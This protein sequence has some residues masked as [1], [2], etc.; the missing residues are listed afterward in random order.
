MEKVKSATI[1]F[2]DKLFKEAQVSCLELN[3]KCQ[4]CNEAVQVIVWKKDYE[5][6]GNGGM[7]VGDW[8]DARPE[9][10]CGECL[11]KDGGKISPTRCEVFSRVVGY[12]RPIQAFNK[13]KKEEFHMRKN[14]SMGGDV[15]NLDPDGH[16]ADMER[17]ANHGVGC[18]EPMRY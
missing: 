1:R 13:G 7:I 4:K 15:T 16:A 6:E 14:Y 2:L 17:I 18:L 11:E 3:G 9:F 8:H 10:K 5:T 12:L